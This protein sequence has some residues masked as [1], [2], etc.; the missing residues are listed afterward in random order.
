MQFHALMEQSTVYIVLVTTEFIT[1]WA[2]QLFKRDCL[3]RREMNAVR[4]GQHSL[5]DYD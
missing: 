5:F 2:R 3:L 4:W 1:D